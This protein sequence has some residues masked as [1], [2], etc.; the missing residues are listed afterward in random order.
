[1]DGFHRPPAIMMGHTPPYYARLLERAGYV[2]AKDLLAYWIENREVPARLQRVHDRLLR[3]GHIVLRPIDLRRFDEEVAVVQDIYNSAWERN[4]GF[5]PMSGEEI[6]HMAK[7][8]RPVVSPHVTCIA[9]VDGEPAGFALGL[10]DYNVAL[11]HVNGRL[12]PFG[13]L[14]LLWYRRGIEHAR[15]ITLGLKPQ[16]RHRGIDALLIAHLF[17]EARKIGIWRSECSWILEDNREM[18]LGLERIGAVA[19]K[20]Y[21]VF[22]KPLA[23]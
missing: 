9:E 22:E 3:D 21:R 8:L 15:T 19:D 18:R 23:D 1:V 11:R 14:K 16:Y 13:I 20:T 5:V 6:R 7:Q 4:W 17:I 12:F 10:P 2:K